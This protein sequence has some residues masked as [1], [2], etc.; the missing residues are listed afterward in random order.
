MWEE[1]TSTFNPYPSRIDELNAR[2]SQWRNAGRTARP[3]VDTPSERQEDDEEEGDTFLDLRRPRT[4]P[5]PLPVHGVASIVVRDK[6]PSGQMGA[7]AHMYYGQVTG[8]VVAHWETLHAS[9]TA[10]WRSMPPTLASQ[11]AW[12]D[13]AIASIRAKARAPQ[14]R[15]D[16]PIPSDP[17]PLPASLRDLESLQALGPTIATWLQS[18][19]TWTLFTETHQAV[20]QLLYLCAS[21]TLPHEVRETW[22][23]SFSSALDVCASRFDATCVPTKPMVVLSALLVAGACNSHACV[24]AWV[25]HMDASMRA[26][27]GA[28]DAEAFAQLLDTL[29]TTLS[30]HWASMITASATTSPFTRAPIPWL[31]RALM[32]AWQANEVRPVRIPSLRFYVAATELPSIVHEYTLWLHGAATLCDA[33]FL[34][35]L[36]A[37]AQ[38]LAWEAQCA[39]R[40]ASHHAWLDAMERPAG[41]APP[42][43]SASTG[44]WDVSVLRSHMVDDALDAWRDVPYG[45]VHRPLH[46]TFRDEPAQDAGG[47]RKEWLQVL[48]DELQ[49][50][51]CWYDLGTQEPS[52]QGILFLDPSAVSSPSALDRLSLL[53]AIMGL[54]L[55]HQITVP[56][57][58]PRAMY[59]LLLALAQNEAVPCTLETLDDV[60]PTLAAGLRQLLACD[61]SQVAAMH[62]T[63]QVDSLHGSHPLCPDG[64]TRAVIASER[65]AYVARLCTYFLWEQIQVPLQALAR[66]FATI[67]GAAAPR[68]LLALLSAAE[69][70]TLLCGRDEMYLDVEALR[71][72]TELVGFPDRSSNEA[73]S[74]YANLDAFW[75]AWTHLPPDEQHALLGFITGCTR[76]PALGPR[77]LGLRLHHVDAEVG[78]ARVPWSSTCTSTLFLPVYT[79]A[80]TLEAKLRI[81]LRHST[82]FGLA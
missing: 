8:S 81:A 59:T 58:L 56:L 50:D 42:S 64:A 33:P 65:Q 52:M 79:N 15:D 7:W 51:A 46:V 9:H 45:A 24:D 62:L 69:L 80:S 30:W 82:G 49:H 2:A 70:E 3:I 76:V 22:R 11:E 36:G 37:K 38:L 40:Q 55:F 17:C 39:M 31:V 13:D 27:M 25:V 5:P 10:P 75:A 67:V 66:G 47:L 4:S 34:L 78:A 48:C 61:A 68:S 20:S 16:S 41:V 74:V 1:T 35:T 77:V 29:T 32:Y 60:Q 26:A 12:L 28:M 72:H 19:A 18:P 63:W 21:D 54:A 14:K 57:R 44:T 53:G 23:A 71:A 6:A 43:P 73:A